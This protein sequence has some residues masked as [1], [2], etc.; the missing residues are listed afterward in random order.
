M[1][2]IRINELARELEVKP[3]KILD[4][5]PGLGVQEKKTHSS[6]ID[7]DVAVLVRKHFGFDEPQVKHGAL[8]ESVPYDEAPYE[9]APKAH[10]PEVAAPAPPPATPTPVQETM[11]TQEAPAE[12]A[13]STP[14]PAPGRPAP[15]RPPLAL[16][17]EGSG[18]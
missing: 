8:D 16:N 11:P 17:R 7:E 2:K 13:P 12:A 1:S 14:A 18:P 6:S 5:L 10:A 3:N 4:L 9:P 15:I